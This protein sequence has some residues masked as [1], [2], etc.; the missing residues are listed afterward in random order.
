MIFGKE[1]N[2]GIV[3]EGLQLKVVEIGK[4]G[5]TEDDILVHDAKEPNPGVHLMLANMRYPDYPI[6][7]GV[8]RAVEG[9]TY[10]RNMEKQ[11]KAVKENSEFKNMDDLLRS[12]N[13]W[14]VK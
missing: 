13:T 7:V 12:G 3:L 14:E 11:V 5:Y 4:D 1:K 10:E 8:I 9:A 2:K 6:A